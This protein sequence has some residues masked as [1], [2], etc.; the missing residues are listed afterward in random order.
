MT[1]DTPQNTRIA[2]IGG[3][4]M[5]FAIIG[6]LIA[7]HIAAD[8]ILA[9]DP[10]ATAR[11]RLEDHFGIRLADS[12]AEAENFLGVA[13]LIILSVKPAHLMEALDQLQ[14]VLLQRQG[15]QQEPVLVLSIVAGV[16]IRDIC[17]KLG[18]ERVIRS[19]PNTPALIKQG[20]TGLFAGKGVKKQDQLLVSWVC[21]AMGQSVWVPKESQLD[22]VT[23]I[24][25][26]GPAY[27]FYFIEHLMRSA[28]KLGLSEE[29]AKNLATQT[30]IGAGL[31][32]QQSTDSPEVLREKVTSKGGTTYAALEVLREQHWGTILDQAVITANQRSQEMGKEFSDH[33][34]KPNN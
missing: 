21:Q 11:N 12:I 31:L 1:S 18:H 25:G 20:I 22:A 4:N 27:V 9:I 14:Q 24:S 33:L 26:S 3:G 34:N 28:I 7:N 8:Q 13:D 30:V 17:A 10:M 2:F 15:I 16:L 29:T 19:M 5:A 32:A 23:A 6:G